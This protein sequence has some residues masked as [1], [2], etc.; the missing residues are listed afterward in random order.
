M[1]EQVTGQAGSEDSERAVHPAQIAHAAW[2]LR[3]SAEWPRVW[4]C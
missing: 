1:N 2:N 4:R 3:D